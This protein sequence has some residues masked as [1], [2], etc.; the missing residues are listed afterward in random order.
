MPKKLK[1]LPKGYQDAVS[2][3]YYEYAGLVLTRLGVYNPEKISLVTYKRMR[4]Y[5]QILFA[6]TLIKAACLN[7]SV[8]VESE[9][10]EQ[11]EFLESQFLK[12][13]YRK[14]AALGLRALDYGFTPVEKIWTTTEYEGKQ[15]Y[16]LKGLK[17]PDLENCLWIANDKGEYNGFIQNASYAVP[18]DKSIWF[19]FDA[20]NGNLY[21]T[22]IIK[23]CYDDWF[24]IGLLKLD[25]LREAERYGA[26]F[27]KAFYPPNVNEQTNK[28][29][30]SGLGKDLKNN[31]IVALPSL[32]DEKGNRMW[33]VE[34]VIDVSEGRHWSEKL[35][36]LGTQMFRAMG[37]PDR[38]GT[39]GEYGAFAESKQKAGLFDQSVD[40]IVDWL[41]GEINEHVVKHYLEYNFETP[42]E[43]YL[44]AEPLSDDVRDF[45]L[46]I[47]REI[48]KW[49]A[50]PRVIQA[51]EDKLKDMGWELPEPEE[52]EG[53]DVQERGLIPG[54]PQN[55]NSAPK[56]K[57]PLAKGPGDIEAESWPLK[58]LIG[59]TEQRLADVAKKVQLWGLRN[60]ARLKEA[61][62]LPYLAEY[63]GALKKAIREAYELGVKEQA[64]EFDVDAA[65]KLEDAQYFMRRARRVARKQWEDLNFKLTS[66][67]DEA[68]PYTNL[69]A[70]LNIR[71]EDFIKNNIA[72][73]VETEIPQAYRRGAERVAV[74]Q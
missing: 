22:P 35:D 31:S 4:K 71:L 9:D 51:C 47:T 29:T 52:V 72:V 24:N 16:V 3:Y 33:D 56:G 43:C 12:P 66:E 48:V 7:V 59:E 67:I 37:I 27:T 42:A 39:E 34:R 25:M 61:E 65:G 17:D 46:E 69:E 8:R 62:D 55:V 38:V 23:A 2:Q 20:E 14:L 40:G 30:A 49:H 68:T 63:E 60:V 26:P 45:I 74:G 13:W 1:G 41:V 57:E 6:L 15:M 5:P 64:E 54:Q 73:T 28:D 11:R 21:G 10:D 70:R 36:W 32:Y 58:G 44:K 53:V 19:S 18:A 50:S